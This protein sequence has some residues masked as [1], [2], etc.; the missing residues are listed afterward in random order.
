MCIYKNIIQLRIHTNPILIFRKYLTVLYMP[1]LFNQKKLNYTG[2]K[3]AVNN[4]IAVCNSYEEIYSNVRAQLTLAR[5]SIQSWYSVWNGAFQRADVSLNGSD[6][7]HQQFLRQLS[8]VLDLLYQNLDS[9]I[10][11]STQ[12]I[13]MENVIMDISGNTLGDTTTTDVVAVSNLFTGNF[14]RQLKL[15]F[16]VGRLY[17]VGCALNNTNAYDYLSDIAEDSND[18][19][20]GF[21]GY[22]IGEFS[23]ELVKVSLFNKTIQNVF[24]NAIQVN[25]S[26]G[27]TFGTTDASYGSINNSLMRMLDQINFATGL[28]EDCRNMFNA[29][30]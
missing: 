23:T 7:E 9:I 20:N 2:N 6:P 13:S 10:T 19:I 25:S 17:N 5:D 15:K 22:K 1:I 26:G 21:Y 16:M 27:V 28:L 11:T 29:V 30:E 4:L 24:D 8:I 14:A 12:P 3:V 18:L